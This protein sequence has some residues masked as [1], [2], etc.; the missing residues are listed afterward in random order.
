MR[1]EMVQNHSH[2]LLHGFGLSENGAHAVFRRLRNGRVTRL[3]LEGLKFALGRRL[4][5]KDSGL[6]YP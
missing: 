1:S 4:Q 2:G 6:S 5:R 3:F